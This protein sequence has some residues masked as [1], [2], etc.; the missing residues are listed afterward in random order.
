LKAIRRD[1]FFTRKEPVKAALHLMSWVRAG[2]PND[3]VRTMIE[4]VRPPPDGLSFT[5]SALKR[6][7]RRN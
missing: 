6:H 4:G 5:S 2:S 3:R 1:E 7:S